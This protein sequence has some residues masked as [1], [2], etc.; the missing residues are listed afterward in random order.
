MSMKLYHGS[1]Q[2]VEKPQIIAAVR[3]LDYIYNSNVFSDLDDEETKIWHYSNETLYDLLKQE[4][5]N[6]KADYPDV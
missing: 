5:T 3:G 6:G 2:I 4:K 1:N